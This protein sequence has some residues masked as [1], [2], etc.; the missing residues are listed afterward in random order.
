MFRAFTKY[1]LFSS[2]WFFSLYLGCP[3]NCSVCEE[4]ICRE[5]DDDFG[6]VL[7]RSNKTTCEPCGRK[8]KKRE[9]PLFLQQ[10]VTGKYQSFVLSVKFWYLIIN[11]CSS[12]LKTPQCHQRV[13]VLVCPVSQT[14]LSRI[15]CACLEPSISHFIFKE[16]QIS[17][18]HPSCKITIVR[19]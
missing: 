16:Q 10:C 6:L 11:D 14:R 2:K 12:I 9:P 8:L 1:K 13:Q 18:P 5:C 17:L 19:E 7:N 15:L 3:R 4:G